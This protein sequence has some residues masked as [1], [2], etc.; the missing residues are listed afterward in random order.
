MFVGN[1]H[2]WRAAELIAAGRAHP[3]HWIAAPQVPAAVTVDLA[4]CG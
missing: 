2:T 1:G 3:L 4:R